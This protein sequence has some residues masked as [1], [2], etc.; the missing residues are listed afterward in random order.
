MGVGEWGGLARG[1]GQRKCRGFRER[2]TPAHAHSQASKTKP[3]YC[4]R[5]ESLDNIGR[6][7]QVAGGEGGPGRAGSM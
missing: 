2:Y 3:Q 6:A 4:A 5:F 1:K 7:G